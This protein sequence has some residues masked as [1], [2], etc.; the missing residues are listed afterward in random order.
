MDEVLP[1]LGTDESARTSSRTSGRNARVEIIT[2]GEPR[3]RWTPEQKREI[4]AESLGP[5]LTPTEVARKHAISSGQLYTWRRE[6]LNVQSAM[7]TRSMPR[8]AEVELEADSS[9]PA[10]PDPTPVEASPPPAPSLPVRPDGLIELVPSG[11]GGGARGC[12]C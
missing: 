12:A 3:R 1:P 4:V 9:Q 6:L 2:R 7:V 5:E 11:R 10:A 8:F